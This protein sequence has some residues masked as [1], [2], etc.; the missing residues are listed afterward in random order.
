M[1]RYAII[2]FSLAMS[3]T[4]ACNSTPTATNTEKASPP[5]QEDVNGPQKL[6]PA[7]TLAQKIFVA[8]GG[9]AFSDIKRIHFTFD[10]QNDSESTFKARHDWDLIN[11]TDQIQWTK[12]DST[13][14]D[15]LLNLETNTIIKGTANDAPITDNEAISIAADA[16]RRWIN[17]TYWLLMPLKLQD[18]G[19]LLSL[20][21]PR[22]IDDVTYDVL[23][24][25]FENVGLTPGDQY[26]VYVDPSTHHIARWD[27]LLQGQDTEPTTVLWENYQKMG[28]L[29]L[30][31]TRRWPDSSKQIVFENTQIDIDN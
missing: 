31:T 28:P 18:P 15:L 27:M 23:H 12:P 3:L 8:H 5:T 24:M 22:T 26:W 30:P 19:V 9:P 16:N 17:D 10:V 4:T 25:T 14:L 1:S 29:T 21:S 20:E 2:L 13:R 6:D 7:Q 11:K